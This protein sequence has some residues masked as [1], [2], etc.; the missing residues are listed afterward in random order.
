MISASAL[1]GIDRIFTKAAKANLVLNDGDSIVIEQMADGKFIELP[2]E[3]FLVLTISSY[4]FRL[5]T[6]LHYSCNKR[7]NDY[8]N[9]S[10]DLALFDN[11]F[12]EIANLCCGAM[13]RDIGHYFTHLGLSTP[14]ALDNK[15]LPFLD[16]LKPTHVRQYKI[17]INTDVGL[18]A[19]LC[20][21]TYDQIHFEVVE[22]ETTENFGTIEML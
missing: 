11:N 20:V 3:R 7:T 2:E 15:C 14:Y 22:Q 5:L 10:A 13:K 9:K 12:G 8:Y 17:D 4:R 1:K 16:E 21:C 6:M 18:H 19:T